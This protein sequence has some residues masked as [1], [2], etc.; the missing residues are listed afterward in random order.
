MTSD[1]WNQCCADVASRM[2]EHVKQFVTPISASEEYG[3]GRAVGSGGYF[4]GA[5]DTWLLT[6]NHVVEEAAK[7]GVLAHLP[8][9]GDNYSGI[10]GQWMQAKWPVDA[11][12]VRVEVISPSSS[13]KAIPKCRVSEQY[14]SAIKSELLF[15]IGFPGTT[16][17]RNDPVGPDKVRTSWFNQ[18]DTP[19]LPFLSQAIQDYCLTHGA[20]DSNKH[21][22]ICY[23]SSAKRA[24]D[25]SEIATPNPKGMSG[26]ILWN[27]RYVEF[28]SQGKVWSPD[29]STV[30]GL[31]W[32]ALSEPEVILATNIEHL[33]AASLPPFA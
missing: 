25:Q 33:R 18:L 4:E 9:S 12:T 3:F 29:D 15:W 19:G 22:A 20:F 31:V 32:A 5:D 26:S 13:K 11:A 30:C 8:N 23:P 7:L 14:S 17:N 24:S 27:T 28:M 10:N 6:A 1:E 21:I 2:F 16:A